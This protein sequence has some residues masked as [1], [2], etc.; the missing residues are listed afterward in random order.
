MKKSMPQPLDYKTIP[1]RR[2]APACL[3]LGLVLALLVIIGIV[4]ALSKVEDIP[5][6]P[7][8]D[9]SSLLGE[10]EIVILHVAMDAMMVL[11]VLIF[12]LLLVLIFRASR[13]RKASRF[14]S[15]TKPSGTNEFAPD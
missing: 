6:R 12:G 4:Y 10:P 11:W 14:Q 15:Q 1:P 13:V 7:P 8:E 5:Y 2:A 3:E 9:M